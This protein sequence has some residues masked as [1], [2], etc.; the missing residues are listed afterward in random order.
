MFSTS[1]LYEISHFTKK[2]NRPTAFILFTT[3]SSAASFKS[4]T[5]TLASSL[6]N[7]IAVALPIPDEAS[8]T[9]QTLFLNC[10]LFF[11]F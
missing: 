2:V 10:F 9:K 6:A 7:D 1:V 3:D 4:E 11:R 8:V 5:T